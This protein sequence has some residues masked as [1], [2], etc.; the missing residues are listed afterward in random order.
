MWMHGSGCGLTVALVRVALAESSKGLQEN[1]KCFRPEN[2]L[3]GAAAQRT[4]H[5]VDLYPTSLE[6]YYNGY[7]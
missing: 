4:S 2:L 3:S 6:P 1:S 7:V 5:D